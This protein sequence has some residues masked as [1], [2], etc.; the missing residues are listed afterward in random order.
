MSK[1]STGK[2]DT[3]EK[4]LRRMDGL[5]NEVKM[6]KLYMF[7]ERRNEEEVSE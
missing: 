5:A 4:I 7:N 1:G 2:S 3:D 6:L